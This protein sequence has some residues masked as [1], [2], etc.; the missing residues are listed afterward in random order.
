ML[1]IIALIVMVVLDQAVKYLTVQN[2]GFHESGGTIIPNILGLFHETNTG[3]AW[4]MLEGNVVFLIVIPLIVCGFIL[5]LLISKKAEH[6]LF[7]WS[8]VLV[9]AGAV[10]NLIDRITNEMQVVDMFKFLFMDFPIFNVADI[11]ITIGAILLFV[12][13]LFIYKEKEGDSDGKS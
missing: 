9:L 1:A 10:G 11:F 13:F 12:Y 3:G 4:S 6:P 5:Y 7:K 2:I 8:L